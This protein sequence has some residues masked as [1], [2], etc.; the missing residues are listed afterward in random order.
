MKQPK[1]RFHL[2]HRIKE[3]IDFK[4]FFNIALLLLSVFMLVFFCLQGNNLLTL[5]NS[6]PTLSLPWLLA[7]LLSIIVVWML[8]SVIFWMIIG[9]VYSNDYPFHSA[10]KVTMVGQYFNAIS[11]FAVAGQPMQLVTLSRQGISTGIALSALIHKFLIYQT[12]LTVYSLLVILFRYQFFSSQIPGMMPLALIGFAAQAGIVVLLLLFSISQKM[13]TRLIRAAFHLLAKIHLVKRPEETSKKV[14]TQLRFYLENNKSMNHNPRLTLR[15]YGL[16]VLQ[17]TVLFS[18]PFFIYKAFHHPGFPI[19]DMV[20][21]QAFVTMVSA[22]TPLPGAAGTSEG[23]FLVVFNLFFQDFTVRQAML[24]WR[25]ITYYLSIIVGS[26]FA[27]LDK[28][29]E[30]RAP[31]TQ[32]VESA[33]NAQDV[34]EASLP[35]SVASEQADVFSAGQKS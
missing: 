20:S 29:E 12:T 2:L 23:S 30:K 18:I 19:V 32:S 1:E 17:L 15:L 11:P 25:F 22:Y 34:P 4:K 21:A 35:S 24:L 7:S 31:T 10:F 14:E 8:E 27:G 5:L 33:S 16:T 9:N 13:T 6:I 26:A 3:R 28:K